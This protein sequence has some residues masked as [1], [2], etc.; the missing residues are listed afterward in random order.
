[1]ART[2]GIVYQ[3][4]KLPELL[5]DV[6]GRSGCRHLQGGIVIDFG[7]RFDHFGKGMLRNDD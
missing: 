5:L 6:L 7:V 2:G 4:T 1:M 3:P